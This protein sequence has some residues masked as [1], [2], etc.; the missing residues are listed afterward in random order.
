MTLRYKLPLQQETQ[1]LA[2]KGYQ[3]IQKIHANSL[4]PIKATKTHKLTHEEKAFNSALSKRRILVEH[5]N[6]YLKRFRILSSR[7]RN[8]QKRF[9]LRF[10][11]I[12]GFYNFQLPLLVSE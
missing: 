11:L 6:R 8:K 10:S 5:V 7:Y 9:G 1:I 2:D 3:G 12:A 4:I